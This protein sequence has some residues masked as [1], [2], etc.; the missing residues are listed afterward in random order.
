M[1]RLAIWPDVSLDLAA[2]I[3]PIAIVSGLLMLRCSWVM[4]DVSI[5]LHI[6]HLEEASCRSTLLIVRSSVVRSSVNSVVSQPILLGHHFQAALAFVVVVVLVWWVRVMV[7]I[8]LFMPLLLGP[9]S[10]FMLILMMAVILLF[11]L[12][13]NNGPWVTM[14]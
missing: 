2:L 1:V 4:A 12:S 5:M 10:P 14:K 9:S 8:P 3:V 13:S 7:V 11:V 6:I